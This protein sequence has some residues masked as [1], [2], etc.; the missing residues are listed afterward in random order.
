MN[1]RGPKRPMGSWTG[2]RPRNDFSGG[3]AKRLRADNGMQYNFRNNE[4]PQRAKAP[5]PV[6]DDPTKFCRIVMLGKTTPSSRDYAL[7]LQ[8]ELNTYDIR[9]GIHFLQSHD[10]LSKE[11]K[12]CTSEGYSYLIIADGRDIERGTY[13]V[14][15]LIPNFRTEEV[16]LNLDEVLNILLPE[17]D[18]P[19]PEPDD[20]MLMAKL[21][22]KIGDKDRRGSSLGRSNVDLTGDIDAPL[23]PRRNRRG[24]GVG[25]IVED[26]RRRRS[27]IT[28]SLQNVEPLSQ[29]EPQGT[30]DV[31]TAPTDDGDETSK[32]NIS[33]LETLLDFFES[34][35]E[36]KLDGNANDSQESLFVGS[37]M[38]GGGV[39]QMNTNNGTM[40]N[41]LMAGNLM[42]NRGAGGGLMGGNLMGN[43]RVGGNPMNQKFPNTLIGNNIGNGV[44][45]GMEGK[46]GKGMDFKMGNNM[47][48]GIMG[49]VKPAPNLMKG[50]IGAPRTPLGRPF[51]QSGPP[52]GAEICRDFLR[53][54]CARGSRC[55]YY[56]DFGQK[57]HPGAEI[58][59]DW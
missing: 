18:E 50:G 30:E 33:T 24:Q 41:G 1:R 29:N 38:S 2:K 10:S 56:H 17:E 40:R 34:N 11:T 28:S 48:T 37:G 32:I 27:T 39:N 5:Q 44:M 58:C 13:G 26:P 25:G 55:R 14:R 42:G 3:H 31:R 49:G 7:N 43:G 20:Q 46:V 16:D 19:P 45:N 15:C 52:P 59:R 4:N 8:E 12:E 9:A 53:N 22:Q 57:G 47:R 51:G 54:A 36:E 35:P 21:R 6:S 23:D